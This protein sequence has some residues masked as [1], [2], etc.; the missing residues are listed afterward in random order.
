[1]T[2]TRKILLLALAPL[3]ALPWIVGLLGGTIGEVE[4][5]G[6]LALI[7]AWVGVF[8]V[9]GRPRRRSV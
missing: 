5:L 8:V 3:L 6:W 1:M 2:E 7:T 4:L 9:S